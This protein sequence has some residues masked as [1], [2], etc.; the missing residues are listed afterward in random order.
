MVRLRLN[1]KS[2]DNSA[3]YHVNV[4]L[5]DNETLEALARVLDTLE[6]NITPLLVES[7]LKEGNE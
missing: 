1:T 6:V 2:A 4:R 5:S 7:A 3:K